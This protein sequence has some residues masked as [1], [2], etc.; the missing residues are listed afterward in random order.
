MSSA[1][2]A[3]VSRAPTIHTHSTV[4][5]PA[6]VRGRK[7]AGRRYN[8]AKR[9]PVENLRQNAPSGQNVRSENAAEK[10][11]EQHGFP[12]LRCSADVSYCPRQWHTWVA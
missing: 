7:R 8:R 9:S 12:T 6:D 4:R 10:L 2:S 5:R 1:P 11:A 3:R